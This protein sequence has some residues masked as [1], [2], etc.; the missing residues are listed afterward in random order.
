M[1]IA[2]VHIKITFSLLYYVSALSDI[3]MKHKCTGDSIYREMQ[4]YTIKLYSSV[5]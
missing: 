4:R 5:A 2:A 3:S 1:M